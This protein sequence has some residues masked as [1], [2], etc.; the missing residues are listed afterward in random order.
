MI[1]TTIEG[2]I[3]QDT[4]YKPE[5]FSSLTPFIAVNNAQKVL[6]FVKRA[7]DAEEVF[8]LRN[9]DGTI[10][11]AQIRIGDSMLLLGDAMGKSESPA[12][13]YHYVADCDCHYERGLGAGA[14][15]IQEPTD[16]FYGDRNAGLKDPCGNIWWIATYKEAL[17]REDIEQRAKQAA[18]A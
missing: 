9:D 1:S 12:M 10:Q 3:M 8:T 15:S 18:H 16:Q 2:V 17:S 7:F 6:D 4:A 11:H 14:S 5:G 13:I